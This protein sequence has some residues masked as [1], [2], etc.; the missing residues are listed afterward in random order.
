MLL[1][2]TDHSSYLTYDTEKYW[3]IINPLIWMQT[4]STIL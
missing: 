3:K 2:S 1:K 4:F